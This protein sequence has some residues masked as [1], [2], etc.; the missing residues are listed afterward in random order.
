[1]ALGGKISLLSSVLEI[2]TQIYGIGLQ[3]K[4]SKANASLMEAQG[5]YSSSVQEFNA[6]VARANAEAIRASADLDIERQKGAAKRL[7][8]SQ[9]AG[10]SKAGVKLQGS[11]L[12]VMIDSAVN[13]KLDMAITDYNANIGIMQA[14]SQAKGYD[15][16]AQIAKSNADASANLSR[17]T[18]RY[19]K[20]QGYLKAGTSLLSTAAD[21]YI[22]SKL[23]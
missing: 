5:N 17:I 16:S 1:M 2:G 13:A 12:D 19:N 23:K 10:Y 11:P 7:K 9:I 8:S 4:V 21:Y 20:Q 18:A 22:K 14:E 15:K 6:A 3:N